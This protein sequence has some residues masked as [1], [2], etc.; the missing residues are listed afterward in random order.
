MPVAENLTLTPSSLFLAKGEV[1]FTT[2]IGREYLL[3]KSIEK[4]QMIGQGSV[5]LIDTPPSLGVLSTNSIVAAR[6]LMIVLR[7]GGFELRALVHLKQVI[8]EIQEQV[9]PTLTI[10]GAVLTI[11]PPR[12]TLNEQVRQEVEDHYNYLGRV[13]DDVRMVE[14]TNGGLILDLKAIDPGAMHDYEQ[15]LNKLIEVC[16][17]LTS[18]PEA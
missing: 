15:V 12:R 8:D 13:R 14:A 9:N 18:N 1:E 7:P 3:K 11:C 5:I 6:S 10:A 17:W 4:T 2:L 16:P